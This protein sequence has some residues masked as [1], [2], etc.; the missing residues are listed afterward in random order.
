M[1]RLEADR[2]L[3]AYPHELSGGMRQRAIIALALVLD[4]EFII[5]DE[6]TTALDTITQHYIFDILQDVREKTGA[7]MLLVTH[8]L[9]AAAKLADRVGVMYAGKLVEIGPAED[10][11]E[12][13]R[14]PY[15][16]GLINAMPSIEGD[17]SRHKAIPGAMPD[18][19]SRPSGC[20]FHPRCAR[21]V[22]RCSLEEPPLEEIAPH[23]ERA[24]WE[25][26]ESQPAESTQAAEGDPAVQPTQPAS[27]AAS[28][29]PSSPSNDEEAPQ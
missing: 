21:A 1:V 15:A 2:V 5:L 18:L 7:S 11:F 17:V 13:A 26:P 25:P 29:S 16:A 4:P 22:E 9:S 6:P 19:M 24:C 20:R 28:S 14:H 10:I 23:H 27:K 3:P 12:R 8:D